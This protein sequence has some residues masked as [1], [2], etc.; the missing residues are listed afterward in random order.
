IIIAFIVLSLI[1]TFVVPGYLQQSSIP[2]VLPTRIRAWTPVTDLSITPINP[3]V[4]ITEIDMVVPTVPATSV[5]S[6]TVQ[7]NDLLLPLA[8]GVQMEMV[9]VPAG[10]FLMG[11]AVTDTTSMP[12]ERPQ[13]RLTLDDYLID[14]YDVTNAQFKA[15]VNATGYKTTAEKVG[16]GY[17]LVVTQWLEVKGAD[18]LHPYGPGSDINGKDNHPVV[19]VSWDDAVAYCAWTSQVTGH[20]VVLPNEA[21]WEKAARGTAGQ[22]YPWGNR[23]PD[24]SRLNYNMTVKDTTEVGRYS[25]IGD[26]PY[27]VADMAANVW[28]WTSSVYMPYPYNPNDGREDQSSSDQRVMR[29]GGFGAVREGVRSARR[30]A[31]HHDD[32]F[33]D[34]GFRVIALPVTK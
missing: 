31:R 34:L 8:P 32:R 7:S 18:W 20:T 25:P 24:D 15:F 1:V 27:A 30:Y 9:R 12:D 28:Q 23:E 29:G 21:Q 14:K 5:A 26:S 10:A 33:A 22:L 16:T 4:A 17:T 13:S 3:T 2:T 6:R 19:L 11:S